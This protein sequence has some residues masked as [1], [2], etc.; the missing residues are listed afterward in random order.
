MGAQDIDL[1]AR[2]G[3]AAQPHDIS[4]WIKGKP[5]CGV[6]IPNDLVDRDNAW[7][8]A[9]V[10]NVAPQYAEMSWTRMNAHN[11]RKASKLLNEGIWW[12]NGGG[13]APPRSSKDCGLEYLRQAAR[14][15]GVACHSVPLCIAS[16]GL[17]RDLAPTA[18]NLAPTIRIITLGVELLWDCVSTSGPAARRLRGQAKRGRRKVSH[19]DI[20]QA[21]IDDGMPAEHSLVLD[22]RRFDNPAPGNRRHIGLSHA[23]L[24]NVFAHR[25][26]EPWWRSQRIAVEDPL[27]PHPL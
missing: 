23:N 22:T 19:E 6:S 16:P 15:I 24:Q 25:K 7:D 2:L 3:A 12:R 27:L 13:C 11:S 26:F 14:S 5:D 9:K 21:L 1:L 17:D 8:A 18:A 10:K 20:R 4:R